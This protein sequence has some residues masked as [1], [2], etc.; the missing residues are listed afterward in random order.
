LK[1]DNS[2]IENGRQDS[3]GPAAEFSFCF[4]RKTTQQYPHEIE[5]Q[6]QLAE[7]SYP[8]WS[9]AMGQAGN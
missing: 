6:E 7:A 1:T 4:I 3:N 2:V 9:R 8:E 5:T